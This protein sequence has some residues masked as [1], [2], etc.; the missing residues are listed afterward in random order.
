MHTE[1]SCSSPETYSR[2]FGKVTPPRTI[3][4]QEQAKLVLLAECRKRG[5]PVHYSRWRL[6][7][8]KELI[9]RETTAANGV[10]KLH[11]IGTFRNRFSGDTRNFSAVAD[12]PNRPA[13]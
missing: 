12:W 5:S 10:K 4:L 1:C 6:M 3:T 7:R 11:V 13:G 9:I 2:R 8:E